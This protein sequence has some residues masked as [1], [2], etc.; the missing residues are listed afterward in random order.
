MK[1]S[2][3]RIIIFF[4]N[5]VLYVSVSKQRKIENKNFKPSHKLEE[6]FACTEFNQTTGTMGGVR[7]FKCGHGRCRVADYFL[8]N[9]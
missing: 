1:Y 7:P 2:T 8:Q 9:P 3:T 4:A 5:Y 6:I